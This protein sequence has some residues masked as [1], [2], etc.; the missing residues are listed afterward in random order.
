MTYLSAV[1]A[2]H[3]LGVAERTVRN[4]INR[5]ELEV[6]S[7]DPIRLDS[8][9]VH[10]VL[11]ARQHEARYDLTQLRQT[12]VT[13]ARETR[14]QLHRSYGGVEL[15]EHRTE[16]QQRRMA[17][18]SGTAKLLFGTAALAAAQL[19]DDSCRWCRA[20]SFAKVLGSWAPTSY[21]EG[22]AALFAQDPCGR[23]GP[24]LYGAV[25]ASLEARVHPGRYRPPDA[26]AEAVAAAMPAA[27]VSR[28]ERAEPVQRGDGGKALVA[29]RL[30]AVHGALKAARRRGDATYELALQAQLQVLTADARAVDGLVAS[31]AR[32]SCGHLAR[33]GCACARR[34]SS[35][36][37]R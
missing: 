3:Y 37:Q 13:L 1:Q 10:E 21:S 18:V 20:A 15:P 5:G 27:A 26:A 24:A 16:R 9:H 23:C 31:A 17:L 4:M 29:R 22:F 30:R 35:R 25:L 34:A 8:G 11:L 28:P 32:L 7:A 6:L 14:E 19:D 36:G 2:G 33:A 12:P